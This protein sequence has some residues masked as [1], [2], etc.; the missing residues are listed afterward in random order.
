MKIKTISR[1]LVLALL[2]ASGSIPVRA[3][4]ADPC[5]LVDPI[6]PGDTVTDAV[7]DVAAAHIDIAEIGSSLSGE[8]LTVVFHLKDLPDT[9]TFNRSE[10]GQGTME[11][12]WEVAID[13]DNDR[14]T[15]PGGFDVLLTAYHVVRASE[16]RRNRTALP[17]EPLRAG[18]WEI[19][20]N[21]STS[22]FANARLEASPEADTI[23]LAGAIPG[24]TSESRLA[25]ATHDALEM[26]E[27]DQIACHDSYSHFAS[28][29]RC[30][31]GAYAITPGQTVA[32]ETEETEETEETTHANAENSALT[33]GLVL[34]FDGQEEVAHGYMDVT[35][36]STSLSGET[37]TVVFHLRDVP[38]TLTFNR[39]G[40]ERNAMEY[41]WEAAIDV[42]NDPTTGDGGFDALLSAYHIVFPSEKEIDLDVPIESK[43]KAGV[44]KIGPMVI[45]KVRDASLAVSA[46]ADTIT[47]SG[48]IP[49]ITADS[50]LVFR[51]SEY[52]GGS[53]DVG[54]YAPA[55][56]IAPISPCDSDDGYVLGQNIVNGVSDEKAAHID[57]TDIDSWLAGETLT[58]VFHLK[59]VPERLIF[60]REGVPANVSEYSWEVSVDVDGDRNTGLNG[61]E[62][63][64]SAMHFVSY[65]FRGR[66]Q[67][68]AISTDNVQTNTWKLNPLRNAVPDIEYLEGA[69]LEVSA[70]EDTI[71]LSGEIPGITEESELAF[72]AYDY[73][74]GAEEI[75]CRSPVGLGRPSP[76]PTSPDAAI[77]TPGQTIHDES[78][79]ELAAHVDI[80]EV[81][82][83]LS[84]ERLTVVF[85]LRDVPERLTFDRS[86][87]P[88]HVPEY[89]WEVSVDVDNDGETGPGGFEY[90]LSAIHVVHPPAR[91]GNR[92]ARLTQ[93]G[94]V[95]TIAWRLGRKGDSVVGVFQEAG[96]EVSADDNTITLVGEIPG[97][98]P[99]SPLKFKTF[100]YFGGSEEIRTHAG[101]AMDIVSASCDSDDTAVTPGQRVFREVSYALPAHV[102]IIEVI[103]TLAGERL[104]VVFHLRDLPEML[105]FNRENILG[106]LLEYKWEVLIDADNDR[107]TGHR[108]FD[109]SLGA[110]HRADGDVYGGPVEMSIEEAVQA[111][112]WQLRKSGGGVYLSDVSV[113]ESTEEDT[114]TLSGEIPGITPQ[115]RLVFEAYDV[116]GGSEWV[117]CHASLPPGG[118]E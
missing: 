41:K 104:V 96:I 36:V 4:E 58:V 28:S 56:L 46:E 108:G 95:E 52:L 47:L 39:T 62:Y 29:W 78:S 72:G 15:G 65:P 48:Y 74:G 73:L 66:A 51:T 106:N 114:I 99:S 26:G 11:Y 86:G 20:D 82:T 54:C 84:G 23:T 110:S 40:V 97:I 55:R 79:T 30:S 44:W 75:G 61:F 1:L 90:T 19:N 13:V 118:S 49:G 76:G 94:F 17:G 27:S 43:A 67:S 88:D 22:V 103:S 37:L 77:V 5:S 91:D 45:S 8:T 31:S 7:S 3:Q 80:I 24:I 70:E 92:V 33:W 98:T 115:S 63:V 68:A 109:Y 38:E 64:L 69:R 34:P 2:L 59:D 102:D 93:P 25:F 35:E 100:D 111:G 12:E 117:A 87:V 83:E 42:D 113:V 50:R 89:L 18:I 107:E 57:I 101:L 71:T 14:S 116:Y 81:A 9:L 85:H 105:T 112:A 6:V 16:E 21:G 32:D 60:D 10:L 53:D